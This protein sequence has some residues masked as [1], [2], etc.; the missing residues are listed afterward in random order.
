MKLTGRSYKQ[1]QIADSWD[2]IVIGSG[3]G[4]LATA[5]LLAKYGGQRVLVLERH[6]TAGGFTHVFRRPGYEWDAGVHYIGQINNPAAPVRA[7]FDHITE[8]RLQWNAM[9]DV[10]DRVCI[11][12]RT[13]DFPS[14]LKRFRA[15]M[16]DRFPSD[17]SA[18]DRYIATVCGTVRASS[19]YFAEKAVPGFVARLIGPVMRSGFLR[20]ASQTTAEVLGSITSNPELIAVL[21]G[22]W[23]DYGLPPRQS[24]FGMHAIVAHHYFEGAGYPVGGASEI[25]SA[26]APVIENAGGEIIYSAEVGAILLDGKGCATGVRMADGRELRAR[27]IISDAGAQNTFDRLLPDGLAATAGIREELREIPAS[28]A[29]VCLY[30]GIRRA[31]GTPDFDATNRWIYDG[32]DHDASFARFAADPAKPWPCLFISFPSAKDPTFAEKYPGRST[33]EVV[34]PVPWAA[35][36][37]WPETRWKRRGADYDEYKQALTERLRADL[38]M[39]VPGVR[40]LIDYAEVST[41]VSTRHFANY[42]HG[43]IYGLAATPARFRMRSLGAR[44]PVKN[45]FLTGSDACTSGVSGAMFGGL[46]AAS[47]IL[48][49]NL[50]S[51]VS[52]VGPKA[53]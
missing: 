3:I 41:P 36:G 20:T 25:A 27:T 38:E 10:Y 51:K 13:Y 11:G 18:I 37:R 28:V 52:R 33:I 14:G 2:A 8:G 5:A 23:G 47:A 24:S 42:Q 46:I 6:Y 4:G 1:H 15:A 22:Q 48:K 17:H 12:E 26:I 49:R 43:E 45:L 40:G 21:T 19:L 30:A 35:F 31:A 34:A 39:H 53:A 29:H 7:A 32:P 44:T 50:V 16:S 9:P